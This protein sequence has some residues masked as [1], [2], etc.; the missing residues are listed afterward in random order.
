MYR[1]WTGTA[2]TPYLN[3]DPTALPPGYSAEQTVPRP[4]TRPWGLIIGAACGVAIIGL[5]VVIIAQNFPG[6]GQVIDTDPGPAVSTAPMDYCPTSSSNESKPQSGAGRVYGGLLSYPEL[7]S[8]WSGVRRDNRLAFAEMA[9]EQIVVD[10]EGY[11]DG[12]SSWVA[13]VLIAEVY[14]GDG[15][16]SVQEGADLILNCAMGAFYSN[17]AVTRTD[18]SSS[19]YTVDGQP[20]W[21]ID[22]KIGFDIPGLN[23]TYDRVLFLMVNTGE[24]TYS[25][26]YSSIPDTLEE[27]LQ[28]DAEYALENLTVG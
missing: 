28:S 5:V 6:I 19:S 18:I 11:G 3:S 1:Y 12:N 9:Y 22:T 27:A 25:V 17:T 10:Q 16:G 21:L 14:S 15:F 26:F 20:G 24:R 4:K 13:S 2:W 23:A 7:G 8:P